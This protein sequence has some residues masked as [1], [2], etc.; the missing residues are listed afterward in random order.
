MLTDLA[1]R[2][3]IKEI[4]ATG[5]R[6]EVPIENGLILEIQTS[7]KGTWRFR[8]RK[9]GR[10]L[11]HT[12]GAYP[13]LSLKDARA[14]TELLRRDLAD[15]KLDAKKSAPALNDVFEEWLANQIIP[16]CT[17]KY[18][19]N[20]RIRIAPLLASCGKMPV[21]KIR[22]SD[23]LAVIRKVEKEE[24]YD[25][26]HR[27]RQVA[28]QVFR[29]AMAL[30]AVQSDPTYALKGA[31]HAKGTKHYPRI[32]EPAR[33][34]QLMRDIRDKGSSPVMRIFLQLHAYTF[35]R[36]GE[37]RLAE[38]SEI[39][40]DGR[41][42]RIPAEKMKMRRPHIVPLSRQAVKLLTELKVLTGH[43]RYLFPSQNAMDG[44][45]PISDNTENK[46]LRDRGYLRTEM[47]GHGFRGMASTLLHEAGWPS[48]AIEVQLAHVDSN[49]VRESYNDA[50]YMKVRAKM[51]QWYA[52]YLD[53]LRDGGKVPAIK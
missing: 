44:S 35:V 43:G 49:T 24:H 45:R 25:T 47:V 15:G 29:Y 41:V 20:T 53:A 5:K 51:V 22:S 40:F 9:D 26:A 7:G 39:D 17:E 42:W 27:L 1:L 28:G 6:K 16:R 46:A 33:V 34:G 21:D 19:Y 8:F 14:R 50:D 2:A 52:D 12:I 23:I 3:K 31:L 30:D 36:P 32:T 13:L 11:K 38:W 4:T 48:Q 18:V 10:T 37:L